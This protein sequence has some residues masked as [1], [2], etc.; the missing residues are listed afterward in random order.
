[1]P[2]PDTVA[3]YVSD[4]P[5]TGEATEA[6]TVVVVGAGVPSINVWL[7]GAA[8]V[9]PVYDPTVYRSVGERVTALVSWLATDVPALGLVTTD[10]TVPL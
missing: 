8:V 1:M 3:V 2:G 6:V 4:W 5:T 9:P 10:Q 7:T